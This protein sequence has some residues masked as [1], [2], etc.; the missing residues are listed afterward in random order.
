M[1]IE[2]SIVVIMQVEFFPDQV[3]LVF[4]INLEVQLVS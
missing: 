4:V 2:Y 3:L 1:T